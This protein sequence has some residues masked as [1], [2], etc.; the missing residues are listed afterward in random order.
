MRPD[1]VI[2]AFDRSSIRSFDKDGR[3]SV[4]LTNISKAGVN[5]YRG[6]EIPGWQRLGLQPDRIYR[7]LRD[8]KELE[9]AAASFNEKP[10]LLSHKHVTAD[11]HDKD[12]TIGTVGSNAV[13]E[14]PYLKNTLSIWD[15]DGIHAV[16]S[17]EQKE[18]SSSYHYSPDMTPG[19]YDG[20]AYDGVMRD[21]VAN[22]VA[23]VREGRAGPDVVVGDSKENVMTV[24]SYSRVG[25]LTLGALI[26]A[27]TPLL[28]KDAKLDLTATHQ[29]LRPLTAKTF[30]A[31]KANLLAS[32]AADT[33]GKLA[34][35]A[36]LGAISEVI[37]M[38]DAHGIGRDADPAMTDPAMADP[39]MGGDPTNATVL[40]PAMAADNDHV[41][42]IKA[43]LEGKVDPAILSKIDEILAGASAAKDEPAPFEGEPE[44]G[45]APRAA[46]DKDGDMDKDEKDK[47]R[48]E[49]AMDAK[50]VQTA[51]EA[52]VQAERK[53]ATA[54]N[55]A[56]RAVRPY[57]GEVTMAFDSAG[58]VYRHAL[59]HMG[60]DVKDVHESAL[61]VILKTMPVP[62]SAQ[63]QTAVAMDANTITDFAKR[64][65][66]AGNITVMQ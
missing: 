36:S 23:L 57:V 49:P 11:S 31:N 21:I 60:V 20:E 39:A 6:A 1:P 41:S 27:I 38:L 18:I 29:V 46:A 51:I 43:L 66:G 4:A 59:K 28:A 7:L 34:N 26:P 25:M 53:R 50:S 30:K 19:V 8:P 62:G 12:L 54:I 40:D 56:V 47:D 5:P 3:M 24:K 9:K 55:E 16:V 44:V 42:Q 35:D 48:K 32:I 22:H 10:L 37:D 65:P 63:R 52:A 14:H 17:D 15:K 61:P 33:K 45:K 64:H 2:I 13:Y 58:E